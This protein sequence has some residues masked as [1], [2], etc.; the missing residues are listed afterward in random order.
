MYEKLHQHL[1]AMKIVKE[2]HGHV[3]SVRAFSDS[4][5]LG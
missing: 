2:E 4:Y 1:N 5:E 3:L